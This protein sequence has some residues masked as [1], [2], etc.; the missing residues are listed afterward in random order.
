MKNQNN[1]PGEFHRLRQAYELSEERTRALEQR[2]LKEAKR[3]KAPWDYHIIFQ[4][5]VP[6]AAC[7]V[8][9]AGG[10]F[11]MYRL[12]RP[13][14]LPARTEETQT[15]TTETEPAV[16]TE[17]TTLR[18]TEP[19]QDT[20]TEQTETAAVT[21]TE[22][23]QTE[24]AEPVTQNMTLPTPATTAPEET[25]ALPPTEL[26]TTAAHTT[27]ERIT[28]APVTTATTAPETS[29]SES[30]ATTVTTAVTFATDYRGNPYL[31]DGCISL[32]VS[33]CK[34]SCT[35]SNGD[36]LLVELC[37]NQPLLCAGMELEIQADENMM[38]TT[39]PKGNG[40][41][42]PADT[43]LNILGYEPRISR[44]G[45]YIKMVFA[46]DRNKTIQP[47]VLLRFGVMVTGDIEDGK[48]YSFYI[49]RRNGSDICV[50]TQEGM[51]NYN[52]DNAFTLCTLVG[53]G[54]P[55]AE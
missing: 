19:P 43:D 46:A 27:T 44:A 45:Q 21:I 5:T 3:K 16:L 23:A 10:L 2:I 47:C 51:L 40:T 9:A 7:M 18:T 34:D 49:D 22:P 14:D 11:T 42:K 29:A 8:L 54:A 15:T 1:K 48:K 26:T 25:K 13:G 36:I 50:I 53:S 30:T 35:I 37:L 31:P 4:R 52:V 38:I 28:T 6:A 17:L 33:G 32:E 39:A 24:T 41:G 55:A 20:A 12:T